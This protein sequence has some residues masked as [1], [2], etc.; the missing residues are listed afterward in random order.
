MYNTIYNDLIQF[1]VPHPQNQIYSLNLSARIEKILDGKNV[2]F[3]ISDKLKAFILLSIYRENFQNNPKNIKKSFEQLYLIDKNWLDL[4][5][6]GEINIL[7]KNNNNILNEKKDI[8]KSNSFFIESISNNII[9][10]L[11]IQSLIKIEQKIQMKNNIITAPANI[12]YD[13]IK[14]KDGKQVIIYK[15]FN[16]IN[17]HIFYAFNKS[18]K[19]KFWAIKISYL[20]TENKDVML[21]NNQSQ[22]TIFIGNINNE[23]YSFNIY[24]ILDFSNHE[25]LN[26]EASNLVNLGINQYIKNKTVF[27]ENQNDYFSPIFS[28]NNNDIKGLCY[29]YSQ[30]YRYK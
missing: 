2:T 18:F 24:Y 3:E 16:L 11:D 10:K 26:H 13:I 9:N 22:N 6:Y 14:L 28:N 7:I 17:Q 25:S 8:I 12:E 19:D 5:E 29:K 1:K 4:Y 21:I 30:N 27:N 15:N 20:N 23:K